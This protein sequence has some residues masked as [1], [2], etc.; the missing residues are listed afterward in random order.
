MFVPSNSQSKNRWADRDLEFCLR[1]RDVWRY[2]RLVYN[3]HRERH[4]GRTEQRWVKCIR[5]NLESCNEVSSRW[6]R[7]RSSWREGIT[8][9]GR[10]RSKVEAPIF[11]LRRHHGVLVRWFSTI[12]VKIKHIF[13]VRSNELIL[14]NFRRLPPKFNNNVKKEVDRMLNA[15]FADVA[16]CLSYEKGWN[17]KVLH[18]ILE[19]QRS[20]QVRQM[21][22]AFGRCDICWS[23]REQYLY[24]VPEDIKHGAGKIDER[25]AIC[26]RCCEPFNIDGGTYE[27]LWVSHASIT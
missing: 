26:W 27:T 5:T 15:G 12:Q 13:D 22:T 19:V 2:R 4:R 18:Q 25:E 17:P 10:I 23:V 11:E 14:S 6:E 9:F 20:D 7:T 1:P 8:S 3:E 24:N 16:N 21:A